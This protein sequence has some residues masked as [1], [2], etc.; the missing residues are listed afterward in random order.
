MSVYSGFWPSESF[1]QIADR[2]A[3]VDHGLMRHLIADPDVVG[4]ERSEQ[5]EQQRNGADGGGIR[6]G[7]KAFVRCR[8]EPGCQPNQQQARP[9]SLGI[10]AFVPGILH[11]AGDTGEPKV[12]ILTLVAS[13]IF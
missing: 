12:H 9:Q 5:T 11:S 8:R 4:E 7:V 10:A 13:L 6:A 3:L 1:G 2:I